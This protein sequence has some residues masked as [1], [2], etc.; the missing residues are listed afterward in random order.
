M[1][2]I[3]PASGDEAYKHFKR[4]IEKAWTIDELLKLSINLPEDVIRRLESV[5]KFRIW[6]S[7]P[8]VKPFTTNAWKS[9]DQGWVVAFYRKG[10]I[11]CYGVIFAKVHSKELAEKLWG[12]NSQ[13]QT[14][15]Y[16]YFIKDLRCCE[17]GIPWNIV[18]K[19]LEYNEGF[20]PRG[21]HIV[22]EDKLR[23]IREK[24]GDILSFFN[25]LASAFDKCENSSKDKEKAEALSRNNHFYYTHSL[26]MFKPDEFLEMLGRISFK[27][28][29]K[30]IDELSL[31]KIESLIV[32]ALKESNLEEHTRNTDITQLLLILNDLGIL[33]VNTSQN[34]QQMGASITVLP[35]AFR[36]ANA[37][38]ACQKLCNGKGNDCF[39]IGG[40]LSV[41][42][43]ATGIAPA[44]SQPLSRLLKDIIGRAKAEEGEEKLAT[45]LSAKDIEDLR[46]VINY[47]KSLMKS[48]S[49]LLYRDDSRE[50]IPRLYVP[51]GIARLVEDGE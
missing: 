16:I 21:H 32:E 9:I 20:V 45:E 3:V 36:A 13:G 29:K 17:P 8:T 25:H 24:Y 30:T 44:R 23:S 40:A 5:G 43:V 11:V 49:E 51:L 37:I 31:E 48:A 27:L 15:E 14:W 50:C 10:H 41:I 28:A 47:L 33:E 7:L 46:S 12:R 19:E 2:L 38:N 42:S 35:L 6:G 1:L 4:T 34:E 39:R 26:R 18:R 22:K